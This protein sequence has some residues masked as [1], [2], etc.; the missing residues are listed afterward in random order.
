MSVAGTG[1]SVFHGPSFLMDQDVVLVTMNYRLGILGFLSLETDDAPGNLGLW[2]QR[3]ALVWVK[4]NIRYFGG[5]PGKV[6]IFGESAGSMSVN[7]H[8]LSPQS[9]GLFHRAILQSGTAISPYT[10][11]NRRP[12]SYSSEIVKNVVCDQS[13]NILKC[14]Q[15]LSFE[16]LNKYFYHFDECSVRADI[17]LTFPGP[18]IPVVDDYS[19]QPFLPQDPHKLV[20]N[21]KISQVPIMIG[22]TKDEGALWTSRFMTDKAF[23]Q[24]FKAEWKTC[25]P[26][27]LL[28]KEAANI[29][30]EDVERVNRLVKTYTNIDDISSEETDL[31]QL[32]NL[33][34]DSKFGVGSHSLAQSL[35]QAGNKDVFKYFYSYTGKPTLRLLHSKINFVGSSGFCDMLTLPAWKM[36]LY[37]MS[38]LLRLPWLSPAPA[39]PNTACHADELFYLFRSR[40]IP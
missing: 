28:G 11:L 36:S 20:S 35:V 7:F 40:T 10:K 12:G 6:T 24:K 38:R 23:A 19:D 39:L 27:N 25:G 29:T 32:T 30:E 4:K 17:S 2:D 26:I 21:N 1:D 16:D 37:I 18:W 33:F 3:E 31:L 13:D 9:R 15:N 14:L 22:F 34:T 8:L 5:D